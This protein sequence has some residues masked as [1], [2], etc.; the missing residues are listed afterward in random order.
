MIANRFINAHA[1]I[2]NNKMPIANAF[3]HNV[4]SCKNKGAM[5]SK[6]LHLKDKRS[7]YL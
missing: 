4:Y 5:I 3:F 6:T 2:V 7:L 1:N